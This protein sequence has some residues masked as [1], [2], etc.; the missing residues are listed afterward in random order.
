MANTGA[1]AAAANDWVAQA[2]ARLLADRTLQFKLGQFEPPPPAPW[3]LALLKTIARV[4]TA[5]WPVLRVLFWL[6]VALA[7]VL[8]AIAVVRAVRGWRPRPGRTATPA[9][10]Q[11]DTAA[12]LQP[13]PRRARALLEEAD[14][15]AADG[16]YAEAAHVLLFRTIDDLEARRPQAV[17]PALT[18]RDIAAL[19]QIPAPARGAFAVIARQ[20]ERS[21]F[22]G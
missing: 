5:A 2:H 4:V 19:E 21:F 13:S 1:T 17:R 8:L 22:G 15:L 12:T 18:T 9:P 11:A 16:R 7:V 14:R 6:G 3:L 10:A 20:V